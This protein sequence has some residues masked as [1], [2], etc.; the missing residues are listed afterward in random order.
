MEIYYV[1]CK[2]NTVNKDS[3]LYQTVLFVARKKSKLIKSHETSGLLSKLEIRT[4]SSN[5]PLIHDIL[6]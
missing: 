2:K 5:I 3:D 4:R 1:S 6:F